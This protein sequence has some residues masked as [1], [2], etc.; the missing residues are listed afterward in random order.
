MNK[1]LIRKAINKMKKSKY[2][3]ITQ[4]KSKNINGRKNN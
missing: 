1:I 2:Y 3:K 4:I